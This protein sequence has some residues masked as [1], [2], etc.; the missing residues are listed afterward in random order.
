[1]KTI[2]CLC[3]VGLSGLLAGSTA[4]AAEPAAVWTATLSDF[5]TPADIVKW[6]LVGDQ[7]VEF[8][9][10]KGSPPPAFEPSAEHATSGTQSVRFGCQAALRSAGLDN[11]SSA[12][13]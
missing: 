3:A 6:Q 12:N 11:G 1:M 4:T 10:I 9:R 8:C 5:D 13:T 2:Q 7:D